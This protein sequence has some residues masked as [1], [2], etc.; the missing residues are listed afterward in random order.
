M[1]RRAA[2][3]VP[4]LIVPPLLGQATVRGIV[5]ADTG[6]TAIS[7]AIVEIAALHLSVTTDNRG[8]LSS[9][10]VETLAG[11]EY[12]VGAARVPI[13]YERGESSCGVLVLW[14]RLRRP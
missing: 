9:V 12:Y 3:L 6:G 4:L 11:V 5:L 13:M 1:A 8:D 14:T 2:H 10:R 7:G